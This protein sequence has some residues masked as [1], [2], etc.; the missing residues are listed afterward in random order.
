MCRKFERG[1]RGPDA[2]ITLTGHLV[3]QSLK[4]AD[5]PTPG[6]PDEPL[7]LAQDLRKVPWF[8]RVLA[9][10]LLPSPVRVQSVRRPG[11][12][13]APAGQSARR[14]VLAA[15]AAAGD[16]PL[17]RAEDPEV[18]SRR[19]RVRLAQ[20][21]PGPRRGGLVVRPKLAGFPWIRECVRCPMRVQEARA[22]SRAS[23]STLIW[24][25][26]AYR[27]RRQDGKT[28]TRATGTSVKSRTPGVEPA[29][30]HAPGGSSIFD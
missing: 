15:G 8:Y 6:F 9:L 7:I 18:L 16:R 23:R 22:R 19:C 11:A 25:I 21:V 24:E 17:P 13:D 27:N 5:K 14:Q 20:A 29:R 26:P 3:S 2:F 28:A 30:H 4:G 10:H 1:D 12:L